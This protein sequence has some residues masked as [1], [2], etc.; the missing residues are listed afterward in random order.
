M[1]IIKLSSENIKKLVAVEITPTGDVVKIEGRNDAG[2]SSVLDSIAMAL[3]GAA[4]IPGVP[5]RQGQKAGKITVDL[6]E[7]IITRTITASGGGSLTVENTQGARFKSPQAMLDK[8]LGALTF[9]PLAFEREKP[10]AQADILRALVGLDVSDLD[11]QRLRLYEDRTLKNRDVK[12]LQVHVDSVITYSDAP[13]QEISIAALATALQQAEQLQAAATGATKELDA[14][15][16]QVLRLKD[17]LHRAEADRDLARV[18]FEAADQAVMRTEAALD[19]HNHA[20][21]VAIETA[22]AA[23]ARVPDTAAIRQTVREAEAVNLQVRT[24]AQAKA[25][26][27]MLDDAEAESKALTGQIDQLDAAKAAKIAVAAFPVVGLSISAEGAVLFNG[28]PFEQAST[29]ARLR[30]SVA[31]GLAL[32]S[33]LKILLVRDGALLDSENLALIAEMATAAGA[34]VWLEAMRE[35]PSGDACSVFISDGSIVETSA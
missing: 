4:L 28:L 32:N 23:A 1:K 2:K 31:I 17:V 11:G 29:S 34:Q 14:F 24:N 21:Q 25:A 18:A 7:M 6:G 20:V 30:V 27:K 3:G 16:A 22:E 8:L 35:S 15:K 33:Q 13:D 9:D 19:A 26:R 5:V 12:A 10:A